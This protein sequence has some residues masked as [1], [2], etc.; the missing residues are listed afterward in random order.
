MLI[1]RSAFQVLDE[2]ENGVAHQNR[3]VAGIEDQHRLTTLGAPNDLQRN[4]GRFDEVID[5]CAGAGAGRLRRDRR[6][7]LRVGDD[8]ALR[9]RC[10]NRHGCLPAAGGQVQVW[11]IEMFVK[12]D[13]RDAIRPDRGRGEVEYPH[14]G[15]GK[16]PPIGAVRLRRGGVEDELDVS[17][18][19]HG[20]QAVDSAGGSRHAH[21][22]GADQATGVRVCVDH[23]AHRQR[24]VAAP[25]LHHQVGADIARPY[26]GYRPLI[27]PITSV[28]T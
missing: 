3:R 2:A 9:H 17:K 13:H 6:H 15:A 7:D 22:C 24:A 4:R 21:A 25:D 28:R 18:V 1:D 12:I 5:A 14:P 8:P 11:R 19:R 27:G 26:D 16:S 20:Q 10:D 23:G